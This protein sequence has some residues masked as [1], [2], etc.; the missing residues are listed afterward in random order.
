MKN[1]IILTLFIL[2]LAGLMVFGAAN[3]NAQDLKGPYQSIIQK[4]VQKFGL[5][6]SDVQTVFNEARQERQ[7]QMQAK[8]EERLNQ[9]V[10]DGKITEAQK[11]AIL[12]KHKELQEKK[13]QEVQSWQN[14]TPEQRRQAKEVQK[15]E[16]ESWAKQNGIDLKYFFGGRMGRFGGMKGH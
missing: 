3:A 1:K 5:K 2:T 14:M 8:F 6:E 4:L 15:Q 12:A 9:L 7:S 11:Q 10:K 16:L 13:Q